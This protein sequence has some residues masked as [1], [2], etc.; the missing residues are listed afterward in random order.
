MTD[1]LDADD[2][3]TPLTP[4]ERDG[5]IPTHIT[6]RGELN[7]LEQRNIASATGWAFERK[8]NVLNEAFSRGFTGEC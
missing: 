3:G 1:V 6:L 5:L 7:E 8:R 2:A 4:A